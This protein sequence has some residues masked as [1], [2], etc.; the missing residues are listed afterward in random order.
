MFKRY[1]LRDYDFKLVLLILALSAVGVIA[2]GSAEPSLQNKQLAGVVAGVVLMV[3]VSLFDYTMVIRLNW[4]M[5]VANLVLLVAVWQLGDETKGATRWLTIGGLRFQPSETAKIL[6]ILFFAQFIM[7]HRKK[8]NTVVI[9]ASCV[10]MY[11]LP[12]IL[13]WKQPDLSTSIVLLAV[14]CIIMFAGGISLKLV[15]GAIAVAIPA[16]ALVIS[17]AL[18]PD[19]D[20]LTD[21]QKT[22]VLAFVNPQ[23]YETTYAYQQLNSVTAIA[24]GQLEGKGYKNNEITSVKNGNFLSEAQTDFIFSVI[25]EEFGFKGSVVVIVLLFSVALECISV[26]RKAKD[27]AGTVIAASMG[28]LVAF[29]G[30]FNIGVATFILPTTGLTLP[31][32]SNGLTS[33]LSLFIGMGF[34]LNVRLQAKKTKQ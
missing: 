16:V 20:L 23:E 28:G 33:L 10:V 24:S 11:A 4:L 25:G 18:Q 14:F 34:V 13:V 6:L 30:F 8:L 3:V 9:I 21:N 12:W 31:F 32:V 5:Y 19:S 7:K 17:L 22:R 27:V 15:F 2:V 29:Q 26:A 1:R